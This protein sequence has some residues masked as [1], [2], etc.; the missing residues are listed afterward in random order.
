MRKAF[1]GQAATLPSQASTRM[2]DAEVRKDG[3][4]KGEICWLLGDMR[5]PRCDV[6]QRTHRL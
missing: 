5:Q 2:K 6:E 4:G 1:L 3:A